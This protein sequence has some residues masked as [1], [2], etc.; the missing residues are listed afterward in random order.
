MHTH[1][2]D[3]CCSPGGEEALDARL[4]GAEDGVVARESSPV[5]ERE[6]AETS[7]ELLRGYAENPVP[8]EETLD[9][10]G[11]RIEAGSVRV[12]TAHRDSR[13]QVEIGLRPREYWEEIED[14][15]LVPGATRS[16]G[17]GQRAEEEEPDPYRTCFER[18]ADRVRHAKV[19]RRLAAKCQVRIS[20]GTGGVADPGDHVRTRLTHTEEVAQIARSVARALGLN[21]ALAEVGALAHDCGHGPCGHA[22]E[23]AFSPYSPTGVHDHAVWGADVSLAGLNLCEETLDAVRCHSWKLPA[24]STPE[25]EVV[26]WAD[27]IAYVCHDFDDAVSAGIVRP[28]DLPKEVREVVG[29]RQS[30]QIRGFIQGMLGATAQTGRIGMLEEQAA[31]LEA[32]R[33]FNYEHIYLRPAARIQSERAVKLLRGLVEFYIDAPGRLP[34]VR[35]GKIPAP[36][37]YT[38]GAAAAAV[39]HVCGMT[40]RLALAHGVELLGYTPDQ[41]PRGV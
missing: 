3:S 38:P 34:Q 6:A 36:G 33:R 26:S 32:F 37:A 7:Q 39:R 27:R 9:A 20:G 29:E 25:G 5:I 24:P 8:L 23:E 11:A 1:T 18:D 40:D 2:S 13:A 4:P 10:Y 28:E 19:F 22:S 21:A 41:L 12:I 15:T 14:A 31:A 17:A 30:R 35:S 16:Q